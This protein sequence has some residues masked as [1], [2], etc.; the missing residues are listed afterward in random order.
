MPPVSQAVKYSPSFTSGQTVVDNTPQGGSV[1]LRQKYIILCRLTYP[2]LASNISDVP[3]AAQDH[4]PGTP[5][6]Y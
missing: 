2:G 3:L 6:E 5:S 4:A 1:K